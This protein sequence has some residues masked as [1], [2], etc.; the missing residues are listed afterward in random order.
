METMRQVKAM[1][2]EGLRELLGPAE[3]QYSITIQET[4]AVDVPCGDIY[5]FTLDEQTDEICFQLVR[6]T[7]QEEKSLMVYGI[8]S[9]ATCQPVAMDFIY[10]PDTASRI[11]LPGLPAGDYL[12]VV[13]GFGVT[14]VWEYDL[15]IEA[16]SPVGLTLTGDDICE[17][18]GPCSNTP[19][20]A[21]LLT[22]LR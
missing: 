3:G 10:S 6:Q 7:I 21:S 18:D 14:G 19:G 1:A 8:V 4:L 16:P 17:Y 13:G 22:T 11:C 5:A 9:A 12:L 20:P 15:T 2:P